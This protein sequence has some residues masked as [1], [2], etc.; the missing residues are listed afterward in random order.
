MVRRW[1]CSGHGKSIFVKGG[2]D[3]GDVNTDY[4]VNLLAGMQGKENDGK[5]SLYEPLITAY[6]AYL[7]G[8]GKGEM[9]LTDTLVSAAAQ[10]TKTAVVTISRNSGEGSDRTAAKGDYYLSDDEVSMLNKVTSAGFKKV[11]VV[12]NIG[13]VIDTSWIRNYPGSPS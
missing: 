4:V 11:A 13:G 5:I 12:L 1:L 8:G 10:N 9:P 7:S 2:W 6:K 3:S